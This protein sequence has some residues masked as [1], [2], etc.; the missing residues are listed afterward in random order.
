[1]REALKRTARGIA[2]V[3]AS[4][5]LLWHLLLVNILGRDRAAEDVSQIMSLAP[6]IVGQYVRNAVLSHVLAACAPSAVIGFGTIFSSASARVGA[7]AY[8][9][10][11][12]TLGFVWIEDDVL[13]AAG[14]QI[15]SGR[16]T[17]AIGG[18]QPIRDQGGRPQQV[19]IGKGSWIGNNA[20]VMADVGANTVVGAGAVVTKALPPN[21]VAAGVPARVIRT[22]TDS[23]PSA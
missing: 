21:V 16:H 5:V 3:I 13:I 7:R 4:P 22:R 20:V 14:A 1:V 8:I 9:G 2:L 6:G 10:P 15:P 19:T 23:S 18:N 17:H 12:C 11:H